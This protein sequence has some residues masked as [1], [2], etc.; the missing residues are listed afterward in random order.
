MT[1]MSAVHRISIGEK[2]QKPYTY[3]MMLTVATTPAHTTQAE[4]TMLSR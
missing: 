4:N 1:N 3:K 2:M